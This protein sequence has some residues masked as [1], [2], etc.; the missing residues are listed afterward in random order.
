MNDKKHGHGRPDEVKGDI[1]A[2]DI[3]NP[4]VH[5]EISD[6]RI[7][8]I[9]LFGVGLVI[10]T[11]VIYLFIAW[12]FDA[13]Q[14]R[15]KKAEGKASPLAAERQRIPPEPRLYLSPKNVNQPSPSIVTDHP[16]QELKKLRAEEDEK[17]NYYN[18]VDQNTGIVTIPIDE[19][20]R[21]VLQKGLLVPRPA[22]VQSATGAATPAQQSALEELPTRSS[23]GQKT[24]KKNQ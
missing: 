20:K 1:D 17:L 22:P 15:E 6:V 23:S 16:F 11:A 9:A 7:R 8:P 3:E 21:L 5:H 10:A 19:A 12:L 14:E 18:W 13:F 4:D 24:E 2:P